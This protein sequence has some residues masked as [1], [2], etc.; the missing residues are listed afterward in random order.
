MELS[1]IPALKLL[2]I[3]RRS[4][5]KINL[6]LFDNMYTCP[7]TYNFNSYAQLQVATHM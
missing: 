4:D 7:I 6:R 5:E 3:N 1:K 2:K